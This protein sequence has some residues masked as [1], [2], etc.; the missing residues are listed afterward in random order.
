LIGAFPAVTVTVAW[1]PPDHEPDTVEV[2]LHAPA[3]GAVVGG[4]V[5]AVVGALPVV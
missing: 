1:N 5:G 3:G 2:A 4:V